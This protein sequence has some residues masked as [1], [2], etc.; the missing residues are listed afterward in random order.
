MGTLKDIGIAMRDHLVKD[1][2]EAARQKL[3]SFVHDKKDI[4]R[5]RVPDT[6]PFNFGIGASMAAVTTTTLF[7]M[8]RAWRSQLSSKIRFK[9]QMHSSQLQILHKNCN[10]MSNVHRLRGAPAHPL[11]IHIP[12]NMGDLEEPE[13]E[14]DITGPTDIP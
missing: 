7:T 9:Q 1:S 11:M 14:I 3:E 8:K 12:E 6:D 5:G 2:M 10:G 4:K 13:P